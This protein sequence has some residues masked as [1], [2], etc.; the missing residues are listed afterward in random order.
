[1]P[2]CLLKNLR[3]SVKVPKAFCLSHPNLV[4]EAWKIPGELLVFSRFQKTEE[5]GFY[6]QQEMV[7][8]AAVTARTQ[9]PARHKSHPASPWTILCLGCPRKTHW[10]RLSPLRQLV[11]QMASQTNPAAWRVACPVYAV[12]GK[13]TQNLVH[14]RQALNQLSHVRSPVVG[15][16]AWM[17]VSA[18][19]FRSLGSP[20]QDLTGTKCPGC[21]S[22]ALQ[23]SNSF[24][25]LS[26]RRWGSW[27]RKFRLPG[28][29][30]SL[31][32]SLLW[33]ELHSVLFHGAVQAHR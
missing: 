18:S 26:P 16:L 31:L 6:C 5:S 27:H 28:T 1:M 25:D 19:D 17:T 20:F 13:Q 30:L 24:S 8:V 23:S 22:Y 32:M 14:A 21:K 7:I 29:L 2:V 33:K 3:T 12:L 10:G 4:L 15:V 11:L 9:V